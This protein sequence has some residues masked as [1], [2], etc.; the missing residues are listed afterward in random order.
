MPGVALIIT[1]ED[2][3]ELSEDLEGIAL[4]AQDLTVPMK[5]IAIE[6]TNSVIENFQ[7]GGRPDPWAPL[8]DSTLLAKAP[9]TKILI[10]DGDLFDSIIGDSGEDWARVSSDRIYAT[11]HQFG[12]TF[13]GTVTVPAHER[14][15]QQAFGRPIAPKTVTVRQHT[16]KM[17]TTIPARPFMLVQDEDLDTYGR[18][19]GDYLVGG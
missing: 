5:V 15:I 6:L 14:R 12:H 3:E 13:S 4:R 11:T 18:I 9:K 8:E 17:N 16:R 7:A 19:I 2:L 10:D 1:I